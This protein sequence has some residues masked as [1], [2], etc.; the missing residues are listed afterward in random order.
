MVYKRHDVIV[1]PFPFTDASHTKLRPALVLS[2]Q[3]RFND[4]TGHIICAMIT[5]GKASVWPHDVKIAG[6]KQVG[7]PR[8][9]FIRMKLFTLDTRFVIRTTGS[10]GKED[11]EAV[12]QSLL[13]VIG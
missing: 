12:M 2:D 7:L 5:S 1:V 10:L 8:P 9:C 3:K 6:L 13:Q 4:A 11:R